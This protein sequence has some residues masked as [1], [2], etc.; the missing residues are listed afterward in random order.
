[1]Y[2]NQHVWSIK[3]NGY[4]NGVPAKKGRNLILVVREKKGKSLYKHDKKGDY[5]SFCV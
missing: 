3:C 5:A 1:M 2:Q 4:L